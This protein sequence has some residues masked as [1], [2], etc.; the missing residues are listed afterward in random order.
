MM[1]SILLLMAGCGLEEDEKEKINDIEFTVVPNENIPQE[2]QSLIENKKK[3][4]FVVS[5]GDKENLYIAIGYGEQPTGGY[6]IQV[7]ELYE[8]KNNIYID[9]EFVGPS[10]TEDIS[11]SNSYPYNVVQMEY[12][13]KQIRSNK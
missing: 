13:D 7:K 4:E 2:L 11:Q 8:T 5:Y 3:E 6:S 9:T 10:K 12:I 1:V